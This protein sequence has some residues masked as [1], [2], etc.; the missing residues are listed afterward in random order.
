MVVTS[1]ARVGRWPLSESAAVG[2]PLSGCHAN[3]CAFPGAKEPL[4]TLSLV[5]TCCMSHRH[6]QQKPQLPPYREVR[7]GACTERREAV[8]PTDGRS[9][10]A[11]ATQ[12]GPH[13]PFSV[14]Q[15]RRH[16]LVHAPPALPHPRNARLS[17]AD[18]HFRCFSCGHC[19]FHGGGG[20]HVDRQHLRGSCRRRTTLDPAQSETVAN[21]YPCFPDGA[22]GQFCNHA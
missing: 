22:R 12:L 10:G 19:R 9:Q 14:T 6:G 8:R 15:G 3:D 2:L 21:A 13:A 1:G 11:R 17:F 20:V 18:R 7:R 4:C 5:L 16:L